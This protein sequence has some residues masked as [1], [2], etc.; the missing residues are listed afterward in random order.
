MPV[1][2]LPREFR[3]KYPNS[4]VAS[5]DYTDIASG[6]GYTTFWLTQ[7][8]T[9]TATTYGLT[10]KQDASNKSD[11]TF[12]ASP[13]EKNFDSSTFNSPRTIKGTAYAVVGY[14]RNSAGGGFTLRLLKVN[15]STET[16]I[17]ALVTTQNAANAATGQYTAIAIPITGTQRIKKGEFLRLEVI[18]SAG[19]GN[20]YLATSPTNVINGVGT[21]LTGSKLDTHLQIPF[22]I[23]Q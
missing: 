17:G 16:E 14:G 2:E 20:T 13:D 3:G 21:V 15:G 5:Y 18:S 1:N 7:G 22:E 11:A 12:G 4:A 6:I 23:N 19:G 9:S 8:A 10:D